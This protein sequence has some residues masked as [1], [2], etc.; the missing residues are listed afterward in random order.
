MK[1]R[2]I[3]SRAFILLLS[4]GAIRSTS[5]ASARADITATEPRPV[6]PKVAALAAQAAKD[7]GA[8]VRFWEETAAAG[9]PLIEPIEGDAENVLAT[10]LYRGGDDITNVVVFVNRGLW[11]EP[12][13][14]AME[15]I[16]ATDVRFRTFK[17]RR[18]ARLVYQLGVNDPLT[19]LREIRDVE[20]W[21]KRSAGWRLDP[22]NPRRF[23]AYPSPLSVAELPG[24][25]PQPWLAARPGVPKGR[26]ESRKIKSQILGNERTIWIYSPPAGDEG[27]GGRAGVGA[28]AAGTG[29]AA[30]ESAN[31]ASLG[32]LILFD[33]AAYTSW[34]PTPTILDNLLADKRIPPLL[35]VLV[36]HP[37]GAR[38]AELTCSD[39]FTRF[40]T[41]ELVPA[42]RRDFP[43]S[44]D[45]ALTVIGGSSYGGLGAA[46]AAF[47]HPEIFGAVLSQSGG[48]MY[49]PAGDPEP[50][51]LIRQFAAS[52]A[53]P[54]RFYLDCGLMEGR[55]AESGAPS[56]LTANRRLRDVLLSKGYRVRYQEFNGGHE[57]LN[58]RG[59]L[60]DGLIALF[61]GR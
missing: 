32:L 47:R 55:P 28:G 58:W 30:S 41:E 4:L 43:V 61:E 19:S 7:A 49:S 3:F 11:G 56:I 51:W 59:T 37:A 25:P 15:R 53:L 57:Y 8:V 24:A 9:T 54:I 29:A 5:A 40:L 20:A 44:P 17:L 60:A 1:R 2:R 38:D 26:V 12:A 46:Y 14:N 42:V 22:L 27:G 36:S 18:D 34:V 45:P 52:P 48:Y 35:A 6:S 33:G 50:E 10:F 31:K 13:D 16:E 23:P 21:M 39:P